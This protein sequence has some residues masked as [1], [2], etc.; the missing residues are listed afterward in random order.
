MTK[1]KEIFKLKKEENTD[2]ED[3]KQQLL[4]LSDKLKKREIDFNMTDNEDL[5]ESLIYEQKALQSRFSFL[6]KQARE[7][8]LEIDFFDRD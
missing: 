4:T 5:I 8:G 7:I 1:I 3:L 2:K 6:M